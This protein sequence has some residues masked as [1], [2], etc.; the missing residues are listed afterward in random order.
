ME[1]EYLIAYDVGTSGTKASLF[2]VDGSLVTSSTEPYDVYFEGGGVCEQD[3]DDWWRAVVDATGKLTAGIDASAVR[4]VSFSGQM[5]GCTFVD[6]DK[7]PLRRSIIWSDTRSTPQEE[8]LV[9]RIGAVR[10]YELTGHRLSCSYSLTKLMWV[11]DHQPDIYEK[12]YKVLNAKDYI[13]LKMT[14]AFVTD[15]SDGS[16]TNGM[17]IKKRVWSDELFEAAGIDKSKMPELH[18]STD[19][20]GTLTAEAASVL[21]LSEGIPVVCG[22]GDGPCATLGAGCIHD[23]QFYLTFG[24]SAWIA[25]TV[26]EVIPD[27]DRILFTFAHVIPERY[28]ATGTMQAAGASYSYMRNTFCGQEL[29]R[30]KK[31]GVGVYDLLNKMI[32]S[33]PVGAKNL[34][35][36]P[37]LTGER[38]PRWNP[39][40]SGSF[41]GMTMEHDRSDYLRATIEGVAMNLGVIL[42]SFR[43]YTDI[44]E[45]IL[46]GGGAKGDIVTG[47][48]ADV[49]GCAII[50]PDH[51]EEATSMAAAVL[52]GIGSGIYSDFEIINSY[53]KFREPVM[54]NP[55]NQALYEERMKVFDDVY[56]ALEPLFPEISGTR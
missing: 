6:R 16:S 2:S 14:G 26:R 13:I 53:L 17:D 30:A 50:R 43:S 3:P 11:R 41:V 40:A 44:S 15:Y 22:G 4:A 38:S 18:Q 25:G 21:G 29:E 7:K 9:E 47:I 32:E 37:Y 23:E 36:L 55:G 1:K 27:P 54:P 20:A 45:L 5:M 42:R 35:Y 48:L 46:T 52:A 28:S 8:Q 49:L 10:G 33:S 51:V 34:L 31:E 39:L 56:Y 19:I 12:T 24:T